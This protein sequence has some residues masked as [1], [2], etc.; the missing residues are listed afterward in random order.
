[1]PLYPSK[2]LRAR[3]RAST[4]CSSVVFNLDSH[5]NPSRSWEHVIIH[6]HYFV[7]ILFLIILLFIRMSKIQPLKNNHKYLFGDKIPTTNVAT[8][9]N[10]PFNDIPIVDIREYEC[11]I[12]HPM[13]LTKNIEIVEKKVYELN[14]HFQD[15]WAMKLSWSEFVLNFNVKIKFKCNS[16]FTFKL[17]VEI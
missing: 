9:S 13:V 2:V 4:P 16:R 14:K 5:L 8:F 7:V 3:E 10:N 17:R 1:M 15:N 12:V 11:T 6:H